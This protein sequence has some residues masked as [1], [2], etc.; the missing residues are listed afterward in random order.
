MALIL[1]DGESRKTKSEIMAIYEVKKTS[2]S[3]ARQ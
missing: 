1:K 2:D 3:G